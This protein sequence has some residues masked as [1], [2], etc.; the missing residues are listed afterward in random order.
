MVFMLRKAGR[1]FCYCL[2]LGCG[3]KYKTLDQSGGD[4]T[5]TVEELESELVQERAKCAKV[6]KE[7]D[8]FAEAKGKLE[9]EIQKLNIKVSHVGRG[10]GSATDVFC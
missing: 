7:R 1:K 8:E 6:G 2:R 3:N 5:P 10:T 4:P 9:K